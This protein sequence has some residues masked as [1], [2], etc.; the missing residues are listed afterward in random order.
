MS[1]NHVMIRT[2]DTD[3]IVFLIG[4]FYS[5]CELNPKS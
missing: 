3:V 2:V 4:Q 5:F 1:D